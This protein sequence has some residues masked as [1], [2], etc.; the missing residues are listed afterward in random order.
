MFTYTMITVDATEAFGQIHHRMPA[1]LDD[2]EAVRIWLDP[3][4]PTTQ[5]V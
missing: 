2:E 4:I 5:V 3:K 1:I